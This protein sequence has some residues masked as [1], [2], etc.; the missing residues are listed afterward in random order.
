MT[1]STWPRLPELEHAAMG[2]IAKRP[3]AGAVWRTATR[4]ETYAEGAYWDRWQAMGLEQTVPQADWNEL[5]LRFIAHL[6]GVACSIV[7][8]NKLAHLE[9]N[10]ATIAKGP[11][12]TEQHEQVYA[13]FQRKQH[14]WIGLI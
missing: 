13:A 1:R 12:P 9:Q 5:A 7:G 2:V 11:L 8:T 4:P 6:P 14:N 10:L 3:L